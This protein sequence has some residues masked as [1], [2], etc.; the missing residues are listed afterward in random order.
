MSRG[1]PKYILFGFGFL[2]S[3]ELQRVLYNVS[4]NKC[5]QAKLSYSLILRFDLF[6][7][8]SP[9]VMARR[10]WCLALSCVVLSESLVELQLP[11]VFVVPLGSEFNSELLLDPV[12]PHC[13]QLYYREQQHRGPYHREYDQDVWFHWELLESY[14]KLV[15]DPEDADLFYVPFYFKRRAFCQTNH[16]ALFERFEDLIEPWLRRFP[17]LAA[18]NKRPRFL[19]AVADTCSCAR[20]PAEEMLPSFINPLK[21]CNPLVHR[22]DL[23][24]NLRV[25]SWEQEKILP[26]DGAGDEEESLSFLPK[27]VVVPYLAFI[28]QSALQPLDT[29]TTLS[30]VRPNFILNTAGASEKH[31]DCVHCGDCFGRMKCSPQCLGLRPAILRHLARYPSNVSTTTQ[32]QQH[33]DLITLKSESTFCLEP[34]GDTLTRRSF[35]EDIM[36]GCIPVVFRNDSYF[37][38]QYAFSDRVPYRD[39]WLFVDGVEL[40]HDRLDLVDILLRIPYEDIIR[41]RLLLSDWA[42]ALAFDPPQY[43]PPNPATTTTTTTTATEKPDLGLKK[44]SNALEYAL[45]EA[46]AGPL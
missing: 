7:R 19:I 16:T 5:I 12:R 43:Q 22:P 3:K 11:R 26:L 32:G 21:I 37:L 27:N 9:S 45:A 1:G 6:I 38:E 15:S 29:M 31:R 33:L 20:V 36:A 35:Y 4:Y 13:P 25:I 28:K 40:Y 46:F 24:S 2:T 34:P 18:D 17:P 42:P 41:K 39:M 23:A 14:G 44:H 10:L 30:L 8:S